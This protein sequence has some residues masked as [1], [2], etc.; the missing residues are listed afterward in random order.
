MSQHDMVIN[1]QAGAGFRADL[2]LALKALASLSAGT[3][4]PA[5]KYSYQFWMDTTENVLKQRNAANTAWANFVPPGA[6]PIAGGT[7][8]GNIYIDNDA[9]NAMLTLDKPDTGAYGSIIRGSR[10]GKLRWQMQLGSTNAESSGNVGSDFVL[11]AWADNGTTMLGSYF[12]INRATGVANFTEIPTVAGT[13][14]GTGKIIRRAYAGPG[15]TAWTKPA[16]SAGL[17]YIEV[18]LMAAGGG[19]GGAAATGV[20]QGSCGGGGGGGGFARQ[21]IALATLTAASYNVVLAAAGVGGT[22]NA[23]GTAGGTSSFGS[24]LVTASGGGGGASMAASATVGA[25][26]YG[27]AGG[28]G[29]SADVN[30]YGNRGFSGNN[31]PFNVG[32]SRGGRG[33]STMWGDGGYEINGSA[34]GAVGI[35]GG[36]GGGACNGQSQAAQKGGNGGEA[37]CLITEYY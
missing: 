2:N 5:T 12:T 4:E 17:R 14:L 13:P 18:E 29:G 16:A 34:D 23:P 36:G 24:T 3:T 10:D 1:N 6:V 28:I 30:A 11:S 9:T 8:T 25:Y 19:G 27:G 26:P 20:G 35:R 32:A 33:G 15:T 31:I 21:L 37:Y 22:G 7:M